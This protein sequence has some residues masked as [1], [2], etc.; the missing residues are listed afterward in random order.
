MAQDDDSD[1]PIIDIFEGS[2]EASIAAT[3]AWEP[4]PCMLPTGG[5]IQLQPASAKVW[6]S[7]LNLSKWLCGHASIVENN[8]VIELGCAAGLPSL[9]CAALGASHVIGTDV[10]TFGVAALERAIIKNN[11]SSNTRAATLDWR[12][13]EQ[14]NAFSA[15][16]VLLA[17]DCN[18]QSSAVPPLLA[19]VDA[20]LAP[21]G[22]LFLASRLAR[23]GL[24]EC[25]ARLM[26]PQ[27]DGGLALRLESVVSFDA[28]GEAREELSGSEALATA[29][30]AEAEAAEARARAGEAN[31]DG[32]AHRLWV[33]CR[34][35]ATETGA[36]DVAAP[37]EPAPYHER[38]SLMRCGQHAINNLLGTASVTTTELDAIA[39]ELSEGGLGLAHRWPVLGNYDINVI[40]IALQ[41]RGYEAEWWDRRKREEELRAV[42]RTPASEDPAAVVGVLLNIRTRP[43]FLGGLVPL[44]RHWLALR[45]LADTRQPSQWLNVDSD[46]PQPIVL[47]D[48]VALLAK[49]GQLMRESDGHL[50]LVR[51]GRRPPAS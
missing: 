45:P 40:L 1:M 27:A 7:A 11:L 36:E 38:Q 32:A 33:L 13:A 10:D 48:D 49:M 50:I 8:E 51:R 41:R 22:R 46:L 6:G 34:A 39:R 30:V 28:D 2:D 18:Y 25:L 5:T 24:A 19:T 15:V 23:F 37:P 42:L 44:G 29:E 20:L 9:V 21:G 43:R 16:P 31:D 17:A 35:S 47:E 14:R 4:A 3:R 12:S 26:R